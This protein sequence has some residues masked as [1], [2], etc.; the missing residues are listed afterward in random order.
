MANLND[1][2]FGI[3]Q[4][5][6]E[7]AAVINDIKYHVRNIRISTILPATDLE[8]YLNCETLEAKKCTIRMS[9]D[10]FQIVSHSFDTIDDL[11]G[12][13]YETPYALLNEI[14][15]G[16]TTSFGYQLTKALQK[17]QREDD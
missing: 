5:P 6:E 3:M 1:S 15:P 7:A 4:W 11:N 13:P 10:G 2:G 14:S 17:I 16:Y 12:F 9:G 8:I